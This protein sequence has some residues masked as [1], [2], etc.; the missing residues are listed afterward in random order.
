VIID[1]KKRRI[2]N[3]LIKLNLNSSA[4]STTMENK[5]FSEP[6]GMYNYKTTQVQANPVSGEQSLKIRFST[7]PINAKLK[8]TDCST[9]T[10]VPKEGVRYTSFGAG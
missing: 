7:N 2:S 9:K 6:Q 1:K 3:Q 8:T 10:Q 4:T 5:L